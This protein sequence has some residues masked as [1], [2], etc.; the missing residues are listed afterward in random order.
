M[1]DMRRFRALFLTRQTD[2]SDSKNRGMIE[3]SRAKSMISAAYSMKG[4]SFQRNVGGKHD[5]HWACSIGD[6]IV[7]YFHQCGYGAIL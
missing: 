2:C 5:T 4:A 7:R 3:M 1:A 6:C